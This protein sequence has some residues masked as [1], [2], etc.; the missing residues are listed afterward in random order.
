MITSQRVGFQALRK[1]ALNFKSGKKLEKRL[2]SQKGKEIIKIY[3]FC[4]V[5]SLR[6][7]TREPSVVRP[8]GFF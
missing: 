2:T 4:K 8:S 7:G 1:T 5:N 3:K 6:K